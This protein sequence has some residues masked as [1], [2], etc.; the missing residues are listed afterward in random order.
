M[1]ALIDLEKKERLS[2]EH[3]HIETMRNNLGMPNRTHA[4]WNLLS[5]KAC[6]ELSRSLSLDEFTPGKHWRAIVKVEQ[7]TLTKHFF[8]FLDS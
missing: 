8:P 4:R 5:M 6:L 2:N 3:L 1:L 7:S